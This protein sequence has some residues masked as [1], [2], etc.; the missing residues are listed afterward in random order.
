MTPTSGAWPKSST[1]PSGTPAT[2]T[3]TSSLRRNGMAKARR[4]RGATT[5]ALSISGSLTR[6][7]PEET[8]ISPV[9]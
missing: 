4:P 6:T 7:P 8:W 3:S 1:P 9:E 2:G 5:D